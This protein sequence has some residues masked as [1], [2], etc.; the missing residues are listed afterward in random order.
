M[1]PPIIAAI[2]PCFVARFHKIPPTTGVK[3]PAAIIAVKKMT[4]NCINSPFAK[5]PIIEING[6][7][8]TIKIPIRATKSLLDLDAFYG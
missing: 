4:I 1:I 2:A 6:I 7:T 3:N 8:P 5:P